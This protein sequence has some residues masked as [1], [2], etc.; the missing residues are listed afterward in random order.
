MTSSCFEEINSQQNETMSDDVNKNAKSTAV[1]FSANNTVK[2]DSTIQDFRKKNLQLMSGVIVILF[3]PFSLN[4]Y[5]QDR[6]LLGIITSIML[7][8]SICNVYSIKKWRKILV[9]GWFFFNYFFLILFYAQFL[10]GEKALYWLYPL[11][12][13]FY[14]VCDRKLAR[15]NL[16]IVYPIFVITAFYLFEF[17]SIVRFSVTLLMLAYFSDLIVCELLKLQQRLLE[18][19][20]R[21]PLTNAYNRRHMN[22]C[23]DMVIEETNRGFGSCSLLL[24]D[25]DFFKKINDEFGHDGGDQILCQFSDTLSKRQRKVDFIFR[26]GGE[27]FVVL[28][29]NTDLNNALTIAENLRTQVEQTKFLNIHKLTVSIG[30]AEYEAGEK[31]NQ[32]LKRADENLYEAKRAGRNCVYPQL[33]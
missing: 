6:L 8:I 28:L 1:E 16:S 22:T 17:Y 9:P 19:A 32:W 2:E 3:V 27:E 7:V 18:L 11:F 14:F 4:C 24:L 29:R 13:S 10:I 31:Y 21:D 33:Q 15:I 12:L 5:F 26:A 23:I 30:V 20:I 25:I